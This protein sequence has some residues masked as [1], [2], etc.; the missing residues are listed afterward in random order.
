MNAVAS[1]EHGTRARHVPIVVGYCLDRWHSWNAPLIT[2]AVFHALAAVCWTRIEPEATLP[3]MT[4][5][6][7][8]A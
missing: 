3:A 2:I 6:G 4:P 1:T 5:A 7:T 8:S